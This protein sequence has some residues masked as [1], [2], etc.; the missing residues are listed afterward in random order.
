MP[1]IKL[2]IKMTTENTLHTITATFSAM[3]IP[4]ELLCVVPVV[5]IALMDRMRAGMEQTRQKRPEP[6][7]SSVTMEKMTAHIAIPS[8][9]FAGG[10]T[11][12]TVAAG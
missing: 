9:F 2:T 1:I 12:V 7:R 10:G 8:L 5:I 6:Q 11:L 3:L 4:A